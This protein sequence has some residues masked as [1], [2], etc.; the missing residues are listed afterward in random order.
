[1]DN[2]GIG[3][4]LVQLTEKL[5]S[6]KGG[7]SILALATGVINFIPVA[8]ASAIEYRNL[9]ASA[10]TSVKLAEFAKRIEKISKDIKNHEV[11]LDS[12]FDLVV[13]LTKSLPSYIDSVAIEKLD[14]IDTIAGSLLRPPSPYSPVD[15]PGDEQLDLLVEER[16]FDLLLILIDEYPRIPE[17]RKRL[18]RVK[19]YYGLKRFQ[20]VYKLLVSLPLESLTRDEIEYFIWSCFEIGY[21]V[22]GTKALK[23]YNKLYTS[24]LTKLFNLSIKKR[25]GM[26]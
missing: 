6:V 20:D 24:R 8:G 15:V 4:Q 19:A 17:E 23:Q 14:D 26:A 21:K 2:E 1:M 25:F 12:L 3:D 13:E 7:R 9:H 10:A 11:R 5:S 18:L 16:N 22:H